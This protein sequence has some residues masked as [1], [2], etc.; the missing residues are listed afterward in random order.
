LKGRVQS[1]SVTETVTTT[2]TLSVKC[3]RPTSGLAAG[4]VLARGTLYRHFGSSSPVQAFAKPR[5]T[6]KPQGVSSNPRATQQ[7]LSE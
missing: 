1:D 6:A 4:G 3:Q 7:K 2:T 5:P